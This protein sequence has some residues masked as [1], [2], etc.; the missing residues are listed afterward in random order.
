MDPALRKPL[1]KGHG[2][3]KRS[4]V[5]G[6]GRFLSLCPPRFFHETGTIIAAEQKN[7][8]KAKQGP[9][10]PRDPKGQKSRPSTTQT[11]ERSGA[12]SE[13]RCG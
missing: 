11:G 4:F 10:R 7:G 8:R 1:F 13:V 6:G 9:L 2:A 3:G 12:A 5:E